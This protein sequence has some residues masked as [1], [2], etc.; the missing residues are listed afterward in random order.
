MDW[1]NIK[2][3]VKENKNHPI[4]GKIT[5]I[6]EKNAEISMQLSADYGN[7]LIEKNVTLDLRK[8]AFENAD[9]VYQKA[10]KFKNKVNGVIEALKISEKKLRELKE[11]EK[12]DTEVFREKEESIKKKEKKSLKWYEKLK[13]T[14]IGGYLIVAGKDATT[15]E[16]LIKRYIEKNDIVFHTLMEGAPFTVIKTEGSEEV[17]DDKILFEVAK[18]AASHSRAWKIG[19]GSADVYWVRPD[20]I[21]KTAESGEYLKKG[22]FVIRGKRNFVRSAALELGIGVLDY[23]GETK[24]TTGTE[25]TVKETFKKW[26]ILKPGKKKKSDLVKEILK[27]FAEFGLDDEDVL[28]VL[29]PGETE[30]KSK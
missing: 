11:K 10:K 13:W 8:N 6:N 26:V 17:P 16:M 20:Q 28:R 2:Q 4:L 25:D 9:E 19:V 24:M 12:T 1:A 18:F 7:G 21:S 27:E 22:A 5:N 15:N 14:I 23:E 29:P 30:I 3:I